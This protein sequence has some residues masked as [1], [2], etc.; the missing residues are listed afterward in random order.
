MMTSNREKISHKRQLSY[1]E[2]QARIVKD[3][4]NKPARKARHVWATEDDLHFCR[5]H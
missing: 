4:G 3:K 1:Q 2:A 5:M